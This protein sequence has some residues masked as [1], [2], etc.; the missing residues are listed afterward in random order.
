VIAS[1]RSLSYRYPAAPDWTL[2]DI[3]LDVEEGTFTLVAGPSAG[4]KSTLLRVFNGL[5]PQFHGGVF[6][7]EAT[8]AGIDPVATA[9][10]RLASVA[11]MVF[12]EPES[13]AITDIVEDEV[14]FGMEQHGVPR[15]HMRRRMY[16]L[17]EALGI[18][19]VRFRAINSLSGG[20]RQRVA[21]AA[22]LALEPR[23]LLLDEPTSQIDPAGAS[24]VIDALDRLHRERGL[25]VLVAEHRLERLLPR[26]DAVIEVSDG[27]ARGLTPQAAAR[28]LRA[29]PSVCELGR[30]LGL[31][32]A[33]LTV[34]AA[35]PAIAAMSLRVSAD[36]PRPAPG[37]V[38][39][40]T[41][42]LTVAYG[43]NVAL[44]DVSID[45]RQG[46]IVALLG[47]N[48]SGKT[49]LFRAISGLV[50]PASGELRMGG[51]PAPRRAQERMAIAGMVPQDPAVALYHDTVREE[52]AEVTRNRRLPAPDLG[53]WGIA[54][55]GERNPRD[56][57]VG[58]QQRV[59][60]AAMLA[61]Q[62]PVWL[63]DEPT[64]GADDASKRWLAARLAAH[65]AAGGAAIVSTHD[66]ESAARFATRVI[67]L[68]S[69]SLVHDLPARE[70]FGH[71]GPF[72]TQ[73]ARLAPGALLPEEVSR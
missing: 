72:P 9:A 18:A 60:L 4:G 64:R 57:S 1:L 66:I 53:A 58:Q 43:E 12:Q 30:K 38:L 22:V 31:D 44:R 36:S 37:D 10:R 59:A 17:L 25:T 63:L 55:L 46:E 68:D 33:P 61:H 52:V 21:I 40:A 28:V 11:G 48:G 69:G 35:E 45:L 54:H 34:E 26:C 29:V 42:G 7:G 39:L 14:A 23:L 32:P 6:Q 49:T 27:L 65:G 41:R 13:Q 5:V 50:Q 20:E 47:P 15:D 19:H 56:V 73:V 71:R 51:A 8:V 2:R 16:A 70:A 67:A 3:N 24:A 62:P